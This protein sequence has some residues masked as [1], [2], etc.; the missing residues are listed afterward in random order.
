VPEFTASIFTQYEIETASGGSLK[1]RADA[2]YRDDIYYSNEETLST[3]E[4]LH[5]SAFTTVNAGV[6]YRLPGG[7]WELGVYGRNLTDK[8]EI[9][10]GF[11]VDA[12]GSTDVA[13][14]EPR[15]VFATIRYLGK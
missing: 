4:R 9:I 3:Y 7:S 10:G 5:A 12:F 11:G 2:S 8:R 13:F 15:K 1:L 6:T 14:N